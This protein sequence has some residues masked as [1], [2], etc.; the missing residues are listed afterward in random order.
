MKRKNNCE[1]KKR[2]R[3]EKR[4]LRRYKLILAILT[5]VLDLPPETESD[6]VKRLALILVHTWARVSVDSFPSARRSERRNERGNERAKKIRELIIAFPRR[7]RS[8]AV[9]FVCSVPLERNGLL[10]M[11]SIPWNLQRSLFLVQTRWFIL[12]NK[13]KNNSSLFWLEFNQFRFILPPRKI[14]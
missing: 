4:L 5:S 6:D 13:N 7:A 8:L 3:F 2:L 10:Q 12:Y 1:F 9:S 14:A 11:L